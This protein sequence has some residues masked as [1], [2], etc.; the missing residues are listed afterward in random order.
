M[1]A[2]SVE[3]PC[4]SEFEN[5]IIDMLSLHTLVIVSTGGVVVTSHINVT[6]LFSF[7]TA[8]RYDTIILASSR[9]FSSYLFIAGASA[10]YYVI[11]TYASC[12]LRHYIQRYHFR[13][14]FHYYEALRH[15]ARREKVK[16]PFMKAHR[17]YFT[18]RP[19]LLSFFRRPFFFFFAVYYC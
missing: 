14:C 4:H 3:T 19:L 9:R 5:A 13:C 1:A 10:T 18:K 8:L 6:T 11:I 16:A 7:H 12:V 15:V 17:C 2:I